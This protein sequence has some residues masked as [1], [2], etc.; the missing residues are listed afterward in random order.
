M[1]LYRPSCSELRLALHIGK[2]VVVGVVV[3]ILM[4]V[5][6]EV[7]V[8]VIVEYQ[9]INGINFCNLIVA[10]IDP[11]YTKDVGVGGGGGFSNNFVHSSNTIILGDMITPA[12]YA[13]TR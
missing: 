7:V 13:I 1:Y 8:V 2:S 11:R 9:N 5:V 4:V 12:V 3:V 10:T 6:A